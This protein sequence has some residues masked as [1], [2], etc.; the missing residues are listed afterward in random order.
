MMRSRTRCPFVRYLRGSSMVLL[1]L[2]TTHFV[3]YPNSSAR[4]RSMHRAFKVN[5]LF[6]S[7]RGPKLQLHC[8]FLFVPRILSQDDESLQNMCIWDILFRRQLC[9]LCR[10]QAHRRLVRLETG[11]RA[12]L[13][14][15]SN[16]V[17]GLVDPMS[18][19]P[20]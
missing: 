7:T 11:D 15:L 4:M 19:M 16:H 18:T 6:Q 14:S 9:S 12:R 5:I 17:N 1:F 8:I 13:S 2:D 3:L 20:K 10:T